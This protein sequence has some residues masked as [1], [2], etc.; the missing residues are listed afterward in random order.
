MNKN[1]ITY[2]EKDGIFYP[3]LA[4]PDQ[5]DVPLGKYSM[6]RLSCLKNHRR[7]DYLSFVTTRTLTE[8]LRD[9]DEQAQIILQQTVN[10]LAQADGTDEALKAENPMRWTGLMNNYRHS[11]EEMVLQDLIYA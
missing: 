10:A 6:L 9:I 4:L 7:A 5:P 1:E 11:A 3:N 8:H 2:T